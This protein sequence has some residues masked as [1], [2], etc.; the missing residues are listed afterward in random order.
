MFSQERIPQI[1]LIKV[2]KDFEVNINRDYA[3]SM[4][5]KQALKQASS[6][7]LICPIKR[8]ALATWHIQELVEFFTV[9]NMIS[10]VSIGIAVVACVQ[11]W[12]T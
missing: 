1:P 7:M 3:Y 6:R 5:L 11:S 8:R 10:L 12:R 4:D 2:S 9:S